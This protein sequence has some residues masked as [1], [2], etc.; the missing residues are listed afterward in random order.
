[1]EPTISLMKLTSD[2]ATV[3]KPASEIFDFLKNLNN[4]EQLMPQDKIENWSSS[5]NECSFKIKGLAGIGMKNNEENAPNKIVLGS[6]GK[7]P[8]PFT[9]TINISETSESSCETQLEFDGEV[10][11][12]M[13]MMIEKPLSNFFN[14]LANKLQEVKS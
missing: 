9:L 4:L 12:F 3:N 7:N 10:N 8:F 13:K 5:E 6:H 14:M 2:K 11:A 1:M